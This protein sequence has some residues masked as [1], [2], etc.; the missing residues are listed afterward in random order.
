MEKIIT[1]GI[2]LRKL[3][4]W[5]VCRVDITKDQTTVIAPGNELIHLSIVDLK[6]LRVEFVPKVSGERLRLDVGEQV[7]RFCGQVFGK[8]DV[9]HWWTYTVVHRLWQR[10]DDRAILINLLRLVGLRNVVGAG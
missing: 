4:F 7:I 8:C 10:L 2:F 1:Q 3:S 5:Q 6:L 9:G